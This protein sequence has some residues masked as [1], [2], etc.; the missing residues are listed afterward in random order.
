MVIESEE[1]DKME[2]LDNHPFRSAR[3]S[4]IQPRNSVVI[5]RKVSAYGGSPQ[6]NRSSQPMGRSVSFPTFTTLE[7]DG[8]FRRMSNLG[9]GLDVETSRHKETK[10]MQDLNERFIS[11]IEKVGLNILIM[12]YT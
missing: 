4:V 9:P 10:D 2:N 1:L 5:Q 3:N 11:Y 7:S 6:W 8:M 12:K